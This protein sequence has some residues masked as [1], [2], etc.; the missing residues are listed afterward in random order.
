MLQVAQYAVAAKG[1]WRGDRENL[2][3]LTPQLIQQYATNLTNIT[4][5]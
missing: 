2:A 3:P 5:R 4:V 1:Y